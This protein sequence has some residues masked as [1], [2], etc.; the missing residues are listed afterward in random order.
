MQPVPV[1]RI[2]EGLGDVMGRMWNEQ[3]TTQPAT[4]IRDDD[5]YTTPRYVLAASVDDAD[6][7]GRYTRFICRFHTLMLEEGDSET[8]KGPMLQKRILGETLSRYTYNPEQANYGKRGSNPMLTPL[9]KGHDEQIWN[10]VY[11]VKCPVP[12]VKVR[13][14]N[15]TGKMLEDMIA[16]GHSVIN[17]T[18][19][20]YLDLVPIRTMPRREKDGLSIPGVNNP[21]FS[22]KLA[23]GDDHVI[24]RVEASGRWENIPICSP[25]KVDES[26]PSDLAKQTA[27]TAQS[28]NVVDSARNK[29]HFLVA[30]VWASESFS[31]RGQTSVSDSSTSARLLE[32]LAYHT[33]L[34]KFDHVYVFDNSDSAS[35][36]TLAGVTGLFSPDLV[37]RI[38]WPHRVCNNNRPAHANPGERSSQYAA[39]RSCLARYGPGTTWMAS[40][41]V[42]EYLI[43]SG[44][45]WGNLRQ[46]LEHVTSHEQST[47]ILSFFQTRALPNVNTMLPYADTAA[48][49]PKGSSN[50]PCLMKVSATLFRLF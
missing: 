31:T 14:D 39:E 19:S 22:P 38:P 45:Q 41:D 32:F 15:A 3:N 11:S 30:C 4:F 10:S 44:K 2:K 20:I 29:T 37:T 25:P 27:L 28:G 47:K 26:S 18:P 7:D 16:S 46:W 5:T 36:A 35:N 33:H 9:E 13:G 48:C 21:S 42:D 12:S 6:A 43:P 50:A 24:P 49:K 34:A 8:D 23:W 17:G 1:K 40:L